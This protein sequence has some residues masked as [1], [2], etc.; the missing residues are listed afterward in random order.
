MNSRTLAWLAVLMLGMTLYSQWNVEQYKKVQAETTLQESKK[1]IQE[2]LAGIPSISN[3]TKAF[4]REEESPVASEQK[5]IEVNTD[6]FAA[7]ISEY[8][9]L[10]RVELKNYPKSL[11]ESQGVELLNQREDAYF[12]A[13]R[14]L[15]SDSGPDSKSKGRAKFAFD[16]ASYLMDDTDKLIVDGVFTTDK[17]V[18]VTKR[19]TFYRDN[20]SFDVDLIVNNNGT[21]SY[22]ALP[23]GRLKM[24][25]RDGKSV[26]GMGI[27]VFNGGVIKTPVSEDSYQKVEF[28]DFGKDKYEYNVVGGW[29]AFVQQY[30]IGAWI[31][32]NTVPHDYSTE[33]LSSKVDDKKIH[34][35]RFLDEQIN[36]APG[37]EEV[38]AAKFY[39][40][41]EI[42]EDLQSLSP[43]LQKTLDYGIFWP[44]AW[45]IF[46]VLKYIYGVVG[47]WGL[48]IIGTTLLIKLLFYKLS[49]SSYRSMAKMKKLQPKMES[50]KSVHGEDKQ[51]LGQAMMQLYK[52]E[53][54]N[55]LGGC[56]PILIQIPVF[57]ALYWVLI[58]S[59]EL[60]QAPFYFW[61]QDLSVK[62]PFY[63]LP[64]IMGASMFLQQKLSPAPPDP[65]QAKV[66]MLMPIVF[67]FLF[68]QFPAG[69]VLYWVANNLLSIA[70][71]IYI[72]KSIENEDS[73]PKKTKRSK[74]ANKS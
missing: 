58:E 57:I 29:T 37:E 35:L 2:D 6:L 52:E 46:L 11:G 20:Y 12:T 54:V 39:A 43:G 62:D 30:F 50:L 36:V 51:A 31:P 49:A 38:V 18:K 1:G 73:K 44:L 45:P 71:Q 67:T 66:M 7:E 55:P 3:S 34:A 16:K 40:G 48:A 17:G 5:T 53:K 21:E 32:A 72:T 9:D 14:G 4:E 63:I 15:L 59:V 8:G 25:P 26:G 42:A 64:I 70:Q 60:R 33:V 74:S 24:L 56:L 61:I 19:Y 22:A 27:R 23:F 10:V 69:L 47:N 13:Q 65:V 41:P 28:D 68:L